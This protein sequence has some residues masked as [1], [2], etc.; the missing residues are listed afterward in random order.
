MKAF[1]DFPPKRAVFELARPTFERF[2][3]SLLGRVIFTASSFEENLQAASKSYRRTSDTTRCDLAVM[4]EHRAVLS[5][6][7][8]LGL[9]GVARRDLPRGRCKRSASTGTC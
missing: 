7:Q 9:P 1:P 5:V 8:L 4:T 3:D 2:K 6:A